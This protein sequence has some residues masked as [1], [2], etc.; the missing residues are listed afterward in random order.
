MSCCWW[1]DV[2]SVQCLVVGMEKE[3]MSVMFVGGAN[4]FDN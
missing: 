3:Q 4:A 1:A 2:H